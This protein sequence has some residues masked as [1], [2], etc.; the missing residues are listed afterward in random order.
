MPQTSP[1]TDPKPIVGAHPSMMD[2]QHDARRAASCR[3]PVLITGETGTGKELMARQIHLA[4]PRAEKPFVVVDCGVLST[5]IARSELFGHVRGAFT[6]AYETRRGLVATA[7]GGTLFLDEVGELAPDLQRQLLRLIQEREYRRVGAT[8]VEVADVKVVAATNRSLRECVT[9]GRFR[10]DLYYRLSAVE[11]RVPPLRERK[12]DIQLLAEHFAA[13]CAGEGVLAK[14]FSEDALL[15][16]EGYDWPGNVRELGHAVAR[17]LVYADGDTI[18]RSDLSPEVLQGQEAPRRDLYCI[19]Y[20]EAR[21]RA[22]EGFCREYLHRALTRHGGNV[23]RAARAS[24]IGRQYFQLRMAE[25]GLSASQ[26]RG[27]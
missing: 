27:G 17:A 6:G 5:D 11:L 24:G 3:L 1:I 4:S 15:S 19:P 13:L 8:E 16:L 10:E 12:S 20:K 22:Q 23:T 18:R 2:V 14:P 21:S 9:E 7:E 26:Y 25:Q